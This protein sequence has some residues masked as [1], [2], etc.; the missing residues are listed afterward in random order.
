MTKTLF[1]LLLVSL[2]MSHVPPLIAQRLPPAYLSPELISAAAKASDNLSTVIVTGANGLT[3]RQAVEAVGGQVVSD[4]W[5]INAV[6]AQLPT[7]RLAA[8]AAYPGIQSIIK[9]QSVKVASYIWKTE[10]KM[11][12]K[13]SSPV[14]VA[15]GATDLHGITRKTPENINGAG[16]TV[17]VIDTG[18]TFNAQ[19][20]DTLG[21]DVSNQFLGQADFTDTGRC[22]ANTPDHVQR[23]GYC[24][25][26]KNDSQDNYGHGTHIAGI[27]WNKFIAFGKEYDMG[28]APG[29]NIL[30]IR[31]LGNEGSGSYIDVIE[32]IQY[33]VE[34]KEQFGTRVINLSLAAPATTPY[35]IDPVSRAAAAA[36][37]QGLVVVA[38][39][40]NTG[41]TAQ[42]ITVPGNNPY[43]ITVGGYDTNNT[44]E[45]DGDDFVA[46]WSSTGPTADGFIKPDV[47]APGANVPSYMYTNAANRGASAFLARN[48]PEYTGEMPMY[49]LNGTS[50]AAGVA[51]GV[52]AL[53]L[54]K[55]PQLTPDQV[56]FRLMN[57]ARSAVNESGELAYTVFQ[58]GSGRIWA[59]DAVLSEAP[60][61]NANSI[62]D[63]PTD[64]GHVWQPPQQE[65]ITNPHD[66]DGDGVANESPSCLT[67]PSPSQGLR[68]KIGSE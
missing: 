49:W 51:S 36:W 21:A 23:N 63:L 45:I 61:E 29:A 15:V 6:G 17:A 43:V 18:V 30:S 47:I 35:F 59:P 10:N 34:T 31:V 62:L 9:D 54:Q 60:E 33:A 66:T 53:L 2:L 3:A 20:I 7:S 24:W 11:V 16:V 39:A 41:P 37:Q 57:T 68:I 38:A 64:L 46:P 13:V 27:I 48:H 52:V 56:K 19:V 44:P 40:G 67:I 28:I 14:S 26:R 1:C 65:V 58:Q 22:H 25:T 42:T 5:L 55:R 8:L 12:W 50:M 32:G 4:L